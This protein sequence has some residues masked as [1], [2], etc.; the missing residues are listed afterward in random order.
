MPAMILTPIAIR[1]DLAA[2]MKAMTFTEACTM[3][4]EHRKNPRVLHAD[5]ERV[6]WMRAFDVRRE[7]WRAR[8]ADVFASIALT[9][10]KEPDGKTGFDFRCAAPHEYSYEKLLEQLPA[11]S[12]DARAALQRFNAAFGETAEKLLTVP[13]AEH[14]ESGRAKIATAFLAHATEIR[15]A[16]APT[17]KAAANAK[18]APVTARRTMTYLA[19]R[20]LDEASRLQVLRAGGNITSQDGSPL[21][22][23]PK[24]VVAMMREAAGLQRPN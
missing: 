18:P 2:A 14:P 10:G 24:A 23:L 17:A 15:A 3:L 4:D 8:C 16:F 1:P 21:T 11:A 6:R 19:W 20:N 5:T 12:F 7:G 22:G 13:L 9:T